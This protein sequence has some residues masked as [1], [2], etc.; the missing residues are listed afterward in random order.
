MDKREKTWEL[1]AECFNTYSEE[2][3]QELMAINKRADDIKHY[4]L[5]G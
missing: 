4:R 3:K 1:L 5:S 2:V